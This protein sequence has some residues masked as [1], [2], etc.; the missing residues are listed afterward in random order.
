MGRE[1]YG[2]T[3]GRVKTSRLRKWE[4]NVSDKNLNCVDYEKNT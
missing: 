3:V 1:F 4:T 2:L